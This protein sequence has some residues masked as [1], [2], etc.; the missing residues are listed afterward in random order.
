M[1][2]GTASDVGDSLS[3]VWP[4]VADVTRSDAA[5]TGVGELT[6]S[7]SVKTVVAIQ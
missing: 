4:S 1:A 7:L 3:G 5:A 2:D 6:A